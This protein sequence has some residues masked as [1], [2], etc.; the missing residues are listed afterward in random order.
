[1]ISTRRAPRFHVPDPLKVVIE[2]GEAALV[3]ISTMGAQVISGPVLRPNQ[4]VTV[5]LPDS[6]RMT[7]QI[8]W[9]MLQQSP[10]RPEAHFRAGL[11]FT[12]A[13]GKALEELCRR[14]KP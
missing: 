4:T 9:S 7:A 3:D 13:A 11:E 5:A 12:E 10:Q 8:A 1:V 14:F 2:G 6:D